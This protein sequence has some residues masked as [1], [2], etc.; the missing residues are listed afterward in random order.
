MRNFTQQP[1]AADAFIHAITE[2]VKAAVREVLAEMPAGA[3]MRRLMSLK[4]SGDYLGGKTAGAVRHMVATGIIPA[5][6]VKRFGPRR[7]FLDRVELDKWI[8]G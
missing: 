4:E 3:P 8:T 2:A 6:A 7:V 5:S 1:S